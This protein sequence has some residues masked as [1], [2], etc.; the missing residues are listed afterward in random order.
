MTFGLPKRLRKLLGTIATVAFLLL[1][2]FFAASLGNL[3]VTKHWAIQTVFFL[4]LGLVWIFP[5]MSIIR[6]MERPDPEDR[7]REGAREGTE[8]VP[9]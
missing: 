5:V 6:F 4:V 3:V 7:A 8:G 2:I 1:Y 9:R